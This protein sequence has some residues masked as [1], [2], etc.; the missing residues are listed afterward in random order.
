MPMTMSLLRG[1]DEAAFIVHDVEAFQAELERGSIGASLVTPYA[2]FF[3]RNHL[4]PPG[5]PD[6]DSFA[7][8]ID[9]VA[10]PG[11]ITVGE[12]RQ[13]PQVSAPAVL[14]CAG[15][16]RAYFPNRQ[17]GAL[18]RV[19]AIGL[20]IWGGVLFSEVAA[21]FGGPLP[22]LR[23]LTTTGSETT[24]PERRVERSIPIA[25]ALHDV[26]LAFELNGQP[27]PLAHGGPVRLV[28]PGYFAVNSVKY[29]SR[30]AFTAEES[31]A[32]IMAS[33]YRIAPVDAAVG[34]PSHPTCWAMPVK[35]WITGPLGEGPSSPGPITV[36]G[37]ALAGENPIERVEVTT[38][39]GVRW[40]AAPLVGPD[41]GPAAWRQFSYAFHA[42][43]G[44]YLLASRA[45]DAAG[46][47]Q[48]ENLAPNLKGYQANGWR[49]PAVTIHVA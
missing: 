45:T 8:A 4:A 2:R 13:M 23:F 38:D 9:G 11:S 12:L 19:G 26:L 49:E 47:V 1:K 34:D 43:P 6:P 24:E 15:N 39:G 29:P 10:K 40:N 32:P 7:I 3:V 17:A 37:V 20:G 25:K 46:N 33:D 42:G 16:G 27:L 30:V 48:P 22:G 18:W 21:R 31:S 44:T 36:G 5:D 35:S 14:Q 41:L 28:V